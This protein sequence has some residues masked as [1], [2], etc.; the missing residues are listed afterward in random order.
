VVRNLRIVLT[1][2]RVDN[3]P[4]EVHE[5]LEEFTDIVVDELP[6]SLPPI[7]SVT[8]HIDLIPGVSFPNKV[9]Y[10]LM[11]QENEEV[12][13]KIQDLLDKGLVKER[14]SPCVFPIVLSPKKDRG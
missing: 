5:L 6:H 2:T 11:P 7:R 14:L 9:V 3:L 1:S 4:E 12:K 13:R 10:R 8:H